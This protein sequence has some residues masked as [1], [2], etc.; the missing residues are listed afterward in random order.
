MEANSCPLLTAP[1]HSEF[2]VPSLHFPGQV[3]KWRL[4]QLLQKGKLR[5]Q[6]SFL[7]DL[8]L[9]ARFVVVT[10]RARIFS[11]FFSVVHAVHGLLGAFTKLADMFIGVPALLAHNLDYKI[12]EERCRFLIAELVCRV[13]KYIVDA[14]K[15]FREN[16][17]Q[18]SVSARVR[19]LP[20]W[21]VLLCPEDA[22]SRHHGKV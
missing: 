2:D 5:T 6:D 3:H 20:G 16:F 10:A 1:T 4:S 9:A 11:H 21:T 19:G 22:A 14:M 17:I 15:R 13:S 18:N 8:A 7:S 12:K